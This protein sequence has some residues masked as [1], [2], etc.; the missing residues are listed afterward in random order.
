[1]STLVNKIEN[2]TTGDVPLTLED[3]ERLGVSGVNGTPGSDN[4]AAVNAQVLLAADGGVNSLLELN[5]IVA[6]ANNAITFL[7]T[8]V[9]A[10]TG[11]LSLSADQQ[12]KAYVDAGVTGVTNDNFLAVNAQLRLD[13]VAGNKDS[14]S[15]IQAKVAAANALLA[16]FESNTP[17]NGFFRVEDYE[18]VGVTGV[19]KSN[20]LMV[21]QLVADSRDQ[22]A[23][24][25]SD[26]QAKVTTANLTSSMA[27]ESQGASDIYQ[28]NSTGNNLAAR[29]I[30]I[31]DDGNNSTTSSF[32][33]MN[34][35]SDGAVVSLN[36]SVSTKT[37]ST[38][39]NNPTAAT[40][41]GYAEPWNGNSTSTGSNLVYLQGVDSYAKIDL[42]A[43]YALDNV[44][45]WARSDSAYGESTGLRIF[46]ALGDVS[47]TY[48]TLQSSVNVAE[49][50]FGNEYS[51]TAGYSYGINS[52]NQGGWNKDGT[53]AAP[54]AWADAAV[55]ANPTGVT[56]AISNGALV[57]GSAS[58]VIGGQIVFYVPQGFNLAVFVAGVNK[59]NATVNQDG[60]W[61]FNLATAGVVLSNT[62]DNTIKL[63]VRD[64]QGNE[65]AS[66]T[67]TIEYINV[68][69]SDNDAAPTIDALTRVYSSG[70]YFKASLTDH[71][72]LGAVVK[73]FVD[74]VEVGH[75]QDTG[76]PSR[77]IS[78][79]IDADIGSG[80]RVVTARI[81][82]LISGE[83]GEL[84]AATTRTTETPDAAIEY[85]L[86]DNA[87][88]L[89][90]YGA[91]TAP[92]FGD[93][94][95]DVVID[96]TRY[97]TGD[98]YYLLIDGT[99]VD[100]AD[101]SVA[102]QT[103]GQAMRAN[104]DVAALDETKDGSVNIA[105]KVVHANGAVVVSD[106][107]TYLYHQ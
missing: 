91:D 94:F 68:G 106:D 76:T 54:D 49:A 104:V 7:S 16:K 50:A 52:T 85:L 97:T 87:G 47:N 100:I 93:L 25:V 8:T 39:F 38:S 56:Q 83:Q 96:V 17:D 57:V 26:L 61:S 88:T 86:V 11:T 48:S 22:L 18:A 32:T 107:F 23:D 66:L 21:N 20:L 53:Q 30:W 41:G 84:S 69:T 59:G 29:Y 90:E 51:F 43:V 14:V 89:E 19:S 46:A 33:E 24:S 99:P 28:F 64:A 10:Q 12:I 62:T 95:P 98:N 35:I 74:G 40:N 79:W 6:A 9:Q 92:S 73:V 103:A 13:T 45:V 71:L 72:S 44:G 63:A 3:F 75:L 80:D 5:A 31:F 4:L 67:K 78:G 27:I 81:D 105:V 55:A 82:N 70:V 77:T 15:E 34:A 1:M 65:Y 102:E 42:G 60:S 58:P 2:Y 101:P 37:A 36:G